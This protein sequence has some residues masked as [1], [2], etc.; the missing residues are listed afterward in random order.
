MP[1]SELRLETRAAMETWR[2]LNKRRE[3]QKLKARRDSNAENLSLEGAA[4]ESMTNREAEARRRR[5]ASNEK[6]APK[7]GLSIS[8]IVPTSQGK[9]SL[10]KA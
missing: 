10:R 5:L 3:E 6:T 1:E 9:D 7:D 8:K 2:R 4:G